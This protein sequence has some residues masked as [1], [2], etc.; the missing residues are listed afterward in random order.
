MSE[1]KEQKNC[2]EVGHK[3]P[4]C[5]KKKRERVKRVKILA[6]QVETL[7]ENDVMASVNSNLM[8]M[9]LDSGAEMSIVPR[10]F[11]RESEYMGETL[12]FMGV[13]IN[14]EHSEAKVA[15]VKITIGHESIQEQVLAVLGE[16]LGYKA[17]LR[18]CC[19]D[20][21]Q[22]DRVAKMMSWKH[23]LPE[24]QKRYVPPTTLQ[25]ITKGAVL[26]S[27]GVV[28]EEEQGQCVEQENEQPLRG[29][30]EEGGKDIH[31]IKTVN[32]RESLT[33][34]IERETKRKQEEER[35][36]GKEMVLEVG[37][38]ETSQLVEAV[39]DAL[40]S[41]T[42]TQGKEEETQ[43]PH[44]EK[45]ES[46]PVV[47][48]AQITEGN[49]RTKLVKQTAKHPSLKT[50]RKLADL[51]EEGYQWKEGIIIRHRL[52]EWGEPYE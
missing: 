5:P 46:E 17:V 12:K 21:E 41:S 39:G 7:G 30:R 1:Q 2:K 34:V 33:E 32:K 47:S 29:T 40:G 19:R 24:D 3:S 51:G 43:L 6:S 50:A 28:V 10:E 37:S 18:F 35:V 36:E 9:T 23:T 8:P 45:A 48:V 20:P 11:V 38:D 25:V 14:H 22:L 44:T 27:E 49:P 13:L 4:Q 15:S 26:V 52:D 42:E 16:D 31:P